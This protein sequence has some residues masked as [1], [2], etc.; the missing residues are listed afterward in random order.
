MSKFVTALVLF[1]NF[2]PYFM[3]DPC[4]L[5][6]SREF[7]PFCGS[8]SK[9]YNNDCLKK[10]DECRTGSQINVTRAGPCEDS[11]IVEVAGRGIEYIDIYLSYVS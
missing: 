7:K 1:S 6:C 2:Y 5:K 4:D 11:P 10:E 9:T 8:N 3:I